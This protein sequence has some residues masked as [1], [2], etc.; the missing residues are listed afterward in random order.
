MV[1]PVHSASSFNMPIMLLFV[2][3]VLFHQH[4]QLA[5]AQGKFSVALPLAVRSPYL[6]CWLPQINGTA[7][8]TSHDAP[9]ATASDLSQVRP[10]S[11]SHAAQHHGIFVDSRREIYVSLSVSMALSTASLD[12]PTT[13]IRLSLSSSLRTSQIE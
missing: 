2:L 6:S 8:A 7:N 5:Q 10:L 13:Q 4:I 3:L 11:E 9:F 12:Q 1:D